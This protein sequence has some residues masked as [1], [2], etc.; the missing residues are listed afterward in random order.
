[1]EIDGPSFQQNH[2][3]IAEGSRPLQNT[4]PARQFRQAPQLLHTVTQTSGQKRKHD[5]VDD[6]QSC[7]DFARALGVPYKP[8]PN[9]KRSP[10]PQQSI[11][12]ARLG[13]Y[14]SSITSVP[15][16]RAPVLSVRQPR[17]PFNKPRPYISPRSRISSDP[18][19]FFEQGHSLST[20]NTPTT[21]HPTEHQPLPPLELEPL[22]P[23]RRIGGMFTNLYTLS[24]GFFASIWSFIT[25]SQQEIVAV[26]TNASVR[27]RRAVDASSPNTTESIIVPGCFPKT[28]DTDMERTSDSAPSSTDSSQ[29]TTSTAK[30][31]SQ[32][33]PT[34][35]TPPDSR[36]TSSQE[37]KHDSPMAG[38]FPKE[39]KH[40]SPK[41]DT[42]VKE[43]KACVSSEKDANEHKT[44]QTSNE[45][46]SAVPV[47]AQRPAREDYDWKPK[48][49]YHPIMRKV[50]DYP[51]YRA[52]A[53]AAA[54]AAAAT[55]TTTATGPAKSAATV[56][57][58]LRKSTPHRRTILPQDAKPPPRYLTTSQSQTQPQTENL[59]ESRLAEKNAIKD[60]EIEALINKTKKAVLESPEQTAFRQ[61]WKSRKQREAEAEEAAQEAEEARLKEEARKEGEKKEEEARQKA[62]E[63]E[64][65]RSDPEWIKKQQFIRPLDP[66]WSEKVDKALEVK[67]QYKGIVKTPNGNEI[68]RKDFDTLLGISTTAT[69]WLND[70]IVNGFLSCISARRLEQQGYVKNEHSVPAHVAFQHVWYN[71]YSTNGR[72]LKFFTRWTKRAGVGGTRL[73]QAEK[74]FFPLNA[75]NHWMLL[76]ISPQD[77][78]IEF[79]DSLQ[80]RYRKELVATARE[81]LELELGSEYKA[82]EWMELPSRSAWQQ[83]SDDCGVFTCL[84]ALAAAK[85]ADFACVGQGKMADARRLMAAVL[86]NGGL[87]GD[88]EL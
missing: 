5:D 77:R 14:N 17:A 59:A 87:K 76:I 38:A 16:T 84:N 43:D 7:R 40:D 86:L 50:E 4:P 22:R 15:L 46:L 24:R 2:S 57:Q 42:I 32:S 55:T 62:L 73:L 51:Y 39:E 33:I 45:S 52:R 20:H 28:E 44:A 61:S 23:L 71:T 54:A 66:E 79:L 75:S 49:G 36:P 64:R 37:Q 21:F 48:S 30:S 63:E 9:R 41:A 26:E 27:K 47:P 69:P 53:A 19:G 58:T 81:W 8:P 34:T 88:F 70:E 6:D 35:L 29:G 18:G 60:A 67:N 72:N 68:S 25:S 11:L 31:S 80:T 65:K 12:K 10:S 1:M 74:L 56:P 78:T 85:G 82:E 83:N 13:V 3:S